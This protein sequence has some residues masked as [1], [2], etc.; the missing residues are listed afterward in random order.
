[1]ASL[2]DKLGFALRTIQKQQNQIEELEDVVQALLNCYK[3]GPFVWFVMK[4]S[5]IDLKH[6]RVCVAHSGSSGLGG[7]A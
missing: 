1:M 7:K 2:E 6:A 4:R 5:V 3:V